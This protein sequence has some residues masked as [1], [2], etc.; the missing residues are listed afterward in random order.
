LDEPALARIRSRRIGF[1]FQSFNL[2]ARTSAAENVALPLF[3]SGQLTG[4]AGKV[5]D[6]LALL[7]LSDR[8]HNHPTSFPAASSSACDRPRADQ[9]PDD[10]AR[11]RADRQPRFADGQR[12]HGDDPGAQPGT[13]PDGCARHPR[14][15]DGRVCRPRRHP[16]RRPR[17]VD[18]RKT[19]KTVAPICRRRQPA[20][21]CKRRHSPKCGPSS[22]WRFSPPGEGSAA[23]SC[24]RR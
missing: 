23:T 10:P 17:P 9:Q 5:R 12:D 14:T 16:Q 11:R 22:G 8:E 1:V 15:S 20:T 18:E 24:V 21:A 19:E 7:G 3:Y 4:S 13:R 6:T 2:L